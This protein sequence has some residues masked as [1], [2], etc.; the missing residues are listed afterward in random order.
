MLATGHVY[1]GRRVARLFGRRLVLG[2]IARWLPGCKASGAP[3][4]FRAIHDDGDEEDLEEAEA[5]QAIAMYQAMPERR[6]T[7][8][9]AA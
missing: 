3:A 5:A 2:T 4:L 1:I 7:R 6:T 9:S 8:V